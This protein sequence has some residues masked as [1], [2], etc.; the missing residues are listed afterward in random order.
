MGRSSAIGMRYSLGNNKQGRTK[1]RHVP[2]QQVFGFLLAATLAA[3]VPPS[4]FA[5]TAVAIS[6][7][8]AAGQNYGVA[9]NAI[10]KDAANREAVE[11][12]RKRSGKNDCEVILT[13]DQL[14]YGALYADCPTSTTCGVSAMSGFRTR[15]EAHE[16]TSNDCKSYYKARS[17][18]PL[19][20]WQ[21]TGAQA[22]VIS[23]SSPVQSDRGE[24]KPVAQN[25]SQGSTPVAA[26]KPIA[27]AATSRVENQQEQRRE[28]VLD[29]G[30]G[31]LHL[32][33]SV[34][35]FAQGPYDFAKNKGPILNVFDGLTYG[36]VMFNAPIG[37]TSV[38]LYQA[39]VGRRTKVNKGDKPVTAE[40]LAREMVKQ[41]GFKERKVNFDCPPSP[42]V[43]GNIVCYKMVGIASFDNVNQPDRVAAHVIAVSSKNKEQGVAIMISVIENNPDKFNANQ[44]KYISFSKKSLIDMFANLQLVEGTTSDLEKIVSMQPKGSD[45]QDAATVALIKAGVSEDKI[46]K[47]KREEAM[48]VDR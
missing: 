9:V 10:G 8:A 42:I 36:E 7:T 14:G 31:G 4:A 24:A 11:D 48:Q 1:M 32:V 19:A 35:N 40:H 17:C 2:I 28:A 20:Q 25:N 5:T 29:S 13:K 3:T 38:V 41:A 21:E 44:E 27:I 30:K 34:P 16:R 12:C 23:A 15:D 43:G 37:E 22:K 47:A 45:L 6:G 46:L 18:M 39:I 26:P 33:A